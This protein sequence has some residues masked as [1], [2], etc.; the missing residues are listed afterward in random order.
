[1]FALAG[2]EGGSMGLHPNPFGFRRWAPAEDELIRQAVADGL[3]REQT[4]RRFKEASF[5]DR[6]IRALFARAKKL[7]L[8][9]HD[10]APRPWHF[11]GYLGWTARRVARARDWWQ[12]GWAAS[13]I[14]TELGAGMTRNAVIGKMTR[15]KCRKPQQQLKRK[16]RQPR[17]RL[18]APRKPGK[19]ILTPMSGRGWLYP[20]KAPSLPAV[21]SSDVAHVAHNDL[22]AEHCRWPVGDP[23]EVA[24]HREPYYCGAPREEGLPYCAQHC[25]RAFRLIPTMPRQTYPTP[26]IM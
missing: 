20:P 2:V 16:L 21:P 4:L 18:K 8:Y 11:A 19:F 22:E 3:T 6:T 24:I 23:R 17:R 13:Q 15:L 9:F 5:D 26:G 14:A 7:G 25:H 10:T 12:A 1:M